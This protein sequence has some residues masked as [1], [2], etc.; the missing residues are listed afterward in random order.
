LTRQGGQMFYRQRASY[1]VFIASA[2]NAFPPSSQAVLE[3]RL[4]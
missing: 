3:P 2:I 4:E 1:L